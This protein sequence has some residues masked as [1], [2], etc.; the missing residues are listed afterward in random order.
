MLRAYPAGGPHGAVHFHINL[1][2]ASINDDLFIDFLRDQ[3]AA[4]GVPAESVCFE[5][6]ETAAVS[7]LQ[8]AARFINQMRALGCEFALDDFGSGLSSFRYLKHLPVDLLKIDGAFVKNM[9]TDPVDRA[10]VA[11]I[12]QIGHVLG[13]RTVAEYVE[14][15]QSLELLRALGVDFA[16]GYHLGRPDLLETWM[17]PV[18]AAG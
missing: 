8:R 10:M 2:G 11:S 7:N 5:I 14:D 9:A 1:S 6:T 4:S 12:N 17:T 13:I 15:A 16:Q 18:R 3:L